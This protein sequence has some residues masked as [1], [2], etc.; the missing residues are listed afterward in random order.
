MPRR[1]NAKGR[2]LSQ[3]IDHSIDMRSRDGWVEGAATFH[4]ML[5]SHSFFPKITVKIYWFFKKQPFNQ[6]KNRFEERVRSPTTFGQPR[7]KS[8][9]RQLI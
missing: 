5:S 8:V 3:P 2:L 9:V 7:A 4:S 6:K 1:T